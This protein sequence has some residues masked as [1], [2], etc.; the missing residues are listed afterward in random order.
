MTTIDER[1]DKI[2]EIKDSIEDLNRQIKELNDVRKQLEREVIA[3]MQEQGLERSGV[4]NAN[5]TIQHKKY[6][7][8]VDWDALYDF[9]YR[10]NAAYIMQRRVSSKAVEEFLLTGIDVPGVT[11]YEEDTLS[12]RK[13]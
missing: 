1:V 10:N 6:P 12:L 8:V 5:L 11:F 9:I 3:S 4:K 7:Q 2:L 13:T